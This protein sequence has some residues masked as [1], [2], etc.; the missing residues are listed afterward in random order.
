MIK[1]FKSLNFDYREKTFTHAIL[2]LLSGAVIA[3][4]ALM[5]DSHASSIREIF[6]YVAILAIGFTV[7][8]Y[9]LYKVMQSSHEKRL[10]DI[11]RIFQITNETIS[12]LRHGLTH[13]S[14]QSVAKILLNNCD[15]SVIA[16][17]DNKSI[18]AYEGEGSNGSV[19]CGPIITEKTQEAIN[20][21]KIVLLNNSNDI[22]CPKKNC[23]LNSGLI[24]PLHY[25]GKAA[26]TITFYYNDQDTVLKNQIIFAKGIS[27]ILSSQ[28]ELSEIEHQE[29]LIFEARLKTL[30]AQ[31][32]PHFLFNTLNTIAMFCRTKPTE[33]RHLLLEFA[34]FFRNS[35]KSQKE[36]ITFKKELQNVDKYLMFE[37]A[38]FGDNLLLT[39]DIDSA[40]LKAKMPALTVQP[41]VENSIR[42]GSPSAN[43]PLI[44]EISSKYEQ[45]YVNIT[46]KDN[47]VGIN[48]ADLKNILNPGFGKGL[49]LGLS[50]VNERLR[51]IYGNEY[52]ISISSKIGEGTSINLQIPST[53]GVKT[54]EYSIAGKSTDS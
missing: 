35:I 22:G 37:K 52:S 33:A 10:L 5:M 42:H 26:A 4:I 17:T 49:G 23:N 11:E 14:A 45:N 15:A 3:F 43:R 44:V 29:A 39:K 27:D 7:A 1:Q 31:I 32:N 51:T 28:L 41:L 16:I 50:N 47:G 40:S 24:A 13:E 19:S 36:F 53:N 12:H 25:K 48:K 2:S 30:Q 38:R 54:K 8:S 34:A 9:F 18:L 46:I 20:K 6:L 21:D